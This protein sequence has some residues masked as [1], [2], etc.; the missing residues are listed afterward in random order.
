VAL[1][2]NRIRGDHLIRALDDGR[3]VVRDGPLRR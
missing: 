3:V 1:D 2:Q